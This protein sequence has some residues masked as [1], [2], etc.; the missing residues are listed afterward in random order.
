[1][2]ERQ[3][4]PSS[5][6]VRIRI[7]S[8]TGGQRLSQQTEGDWYA[9]G[10]HYYVR[11]AEAS[12]EGGQT[13]TIVKLEPNAIKIMRRGDVQADQTFV[14]GEKRLGY[15]ETAGVRLELETRT[16][17]W[18]QDLQDGFGTVLW[19]YSLEIAG[20]PAQTCSVKLTIEDIQE[21]PK[22]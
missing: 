16:M 8:R 15:Y 5:R 18:E 14:P 9:K 12:P 7:D 10:S 6:R 3:P 2:S 13:T 17:R 21:D 1:M 11:Y 19:S 22:L 4:M 20:A